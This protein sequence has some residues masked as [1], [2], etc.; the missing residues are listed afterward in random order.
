M[1]KSCS[2][3]SAIRHVHSIENDYV[4]AVEIKN[5]M[6]GYLSLHRHMS[7]RALEMNVIQDMQ[8][9]KSALSLESFQRI[10]SK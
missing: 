7:Q 10:F 8:N 6:W 2:K 9:Y 3:K 1:K 5:L 4:P